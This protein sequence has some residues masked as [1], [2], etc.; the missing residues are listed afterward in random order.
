VGPAHLRVGWRP[1]SP[2]E[3][4]R[5]PDRK[6]KTALPAKKNLCSARLAVQHCPFMSSSDHFLTLFGFV[7]Q[8]P[9]AYGYATD[10]MRPD[11]AAE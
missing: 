10:A 6:E 5:L 2:A 7:L 9:S 3:V 11:L 8:S 1:L 4:I